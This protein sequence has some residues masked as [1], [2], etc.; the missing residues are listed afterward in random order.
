MGKLLVTRNESHTPPKGHTQMKAQIAAK[1][2]QFL[3]NKKANKN[4]GFTLIELL[5]VIIIIGILSAIALPS[6]LNQA[7]KAKQSEAKTTISAVN[8]AQAERRGGVEGAYADN[9]SSLSLGLA[10][11]SGSYGFSVNGGVDTAQ[12]LSFNSDTALKT[13]TGAN[14]TFKDN[15]SA[16]VTAT[17]VCE[18]LAASGNVAGLAPGALAPGARTVE[19]AATCNAAQKNLARP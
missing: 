8:A 9:M 11:Q 19:T 5:V 4:S 13:Y 16:S 15:A 7:A 14:V 6:F 3:S 18:A 12:I 1:Y 10:T 2:I 17:I